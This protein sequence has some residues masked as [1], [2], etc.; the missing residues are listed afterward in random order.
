[1]LFRSCQLYHRD[2]MIFRDRLSATRQLLP[3]LEVHRRHPGVVIALPRGGVPM[4]AEIAS[5][6]DWPMH[7]LAVKKLP[8]P[9]KPEYA[10][11]AVGL[12][13]FVI[14]DPHADISKEYVDREVS[15][16]QGLLRRR[17]ASYH[18]PELNV[19]GKT[20]IIVDDGIATGLTMRYAISVM[21][22]HKPRSIIIAV[23]VAASDAVRELHPLVD[24]FVVLHV[25]ASFGA[26]GEWYES[27][28]EVTDEDVQRC[29]AVDLQNGTQYQPVGRSVLGQ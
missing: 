27:F 11:G 18:Q 14:D 24:E 13:D 25:P 16:L 4:A 20:V 26:V 2:V 23:P 10:I 3:L 8:H 12:H 7:V 6:L 9:E 29:L 22:T 5:H 1:M 17:E 21:R 28:A 15:R 19:D